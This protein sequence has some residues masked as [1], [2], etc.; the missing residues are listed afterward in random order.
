MSFKEEKF[1]E[2]IQPYLYR[3]IGKVLWEKKLG[4]DP[5]KNLEKYSKELTKIVSKVAEDCLEEGTQILKKPKKKLDILNWWG[6]HTVKAFANERL[7]F[8][9]GSFV[10]KDA[11]YEAY[12]TYCKSHGDMAYE[13][14]SKNVFSKILLRL[15]PKIQTAQKRISGKPTY[16]WRDLKLTNVVQ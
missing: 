5:T 2:A 11:V 4:K 16:Y 8:S 1:E 6:A 9:P 13:Y 3:F 10:T 14:V 12:M 15:I 7:E